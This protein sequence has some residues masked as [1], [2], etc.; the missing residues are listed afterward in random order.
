MRLLTALLLAISFSCNISP[1]ENHNQTS[2]PRS[3]IQ[4]TIEIN[5]I[6]KVLIDQRNYWNNGDINGFMQGYWNSESLVFTSANHKP[7][8]GWENT[9]KRYK[10]SYPDRYSMGKFRFEILDL[11]LISEDKAKLKGEWELIRIKDNPK[12]LFW[13]DLEKFDNNWLITKDSTIEF[14]IPN[15]L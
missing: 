4:D 11:K 13:L 12:G 14:E 7:E 3:I 6:K 15:P 1:K 8:C 9:L 2:H 10:N 5:K